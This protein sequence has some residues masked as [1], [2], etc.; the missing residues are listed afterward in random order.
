MFLNL[1]S[2]RKIVSI[3]AFVG[4]HYLDVKR[5]DPTGYEQVIPVSQAFIHDDFDITTMVIYPKRKSSYRKSPPP[6]KN[7]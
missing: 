6:H 3:T 2:F 7:F 5:F 1:G 4:Y